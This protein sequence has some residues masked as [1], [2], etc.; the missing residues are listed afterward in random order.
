MNKI[1]IG[2]TAIKHWYSDF[3]R[4]PKDID[5][6]TD[7]EKIKGSYGIE[8][9]YNPVIFKYSK[10]EYLEPNLLLTLKASH[11]CWDINWDKH[12]WDI[13]F[14]LSKGNKI[15]KP[16]FWELY[17][18]WN[19]YH[20]VNKRSNLT[21]S[22]EQFFTNAVNYDTIEHDNL[23]LLINPIPIYTKV[24]KDGCEVELDENKFNNLT[25]EDK[26]AFVKEEVMVM[27]WE[28]YK[29]LFF[30]AAYYKMLKKFI[31]DHAPLFSL[32]FIIENYKTLIQINFDYFKT[33][34]NGLQKIKQ[35]A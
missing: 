18:F 24:L 20:T 26:L 10:G 11:I 25:F 5:Y 6:A 35:L 8:Y 14:L 23:H 17:Q 4:M 7:E 19:E 34:K 28:R 22:K 27:S 12:M 15:I 33:I 3:N 21:M 2:S 30:K 9:L 32:L 29:S 13:Q 31:R 1:I 16:V